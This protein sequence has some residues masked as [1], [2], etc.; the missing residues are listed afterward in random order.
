M[1]L[2]V[3]VWCYAIFFSTDDGVASETPNGHA[4]PS[5]TIEEVKVDIEASD[6]K[7]N[8][9]ANGDEKAGNINAVCAILKQVLKFQ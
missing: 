7:T 3:H 2:C 4:M 5:V 9:E 6:K 8:P 1:C